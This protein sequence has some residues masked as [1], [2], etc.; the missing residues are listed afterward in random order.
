MQAWQIFVQEVALSVSVVISFVNEFI[1]LQL[2]V[3]EAQKT[4]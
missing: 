2:Q 3:F 1:D 4:F